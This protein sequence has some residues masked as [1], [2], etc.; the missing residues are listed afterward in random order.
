M[1]AF[2]NIVFTSLDS[3][4]LVDA[5]SYAW[6]FGDGVTTN[7]SSTATHA[8]APGTWTAKLTLTKNGFPVSTTLAL[9]VPAPPE[10]PKWVVP[11]MAYVL[12]QVAGTTWQSDVT[13]MNPSALS[14][15]YSVAFLDARNPVTDYSQLTWTPITVDPL[16]VI[17]SGNL[18][19]GPPFNQPLGAY[20]ALMV[21]GDVAPLPP[22]ITARTFNNGDPTKGT[23]G[24]SVPQSS[25]SG[26]VSTQAAAAA[27]VLIGL[28][29]NATAYT[30]IGL[31][32]LHNDWATVELDFYDGATAADLGTLTVQINPYQSYQINKALQDPR[33]VPAA[34]YSGS[35]DLYSVLVKVTEGTGVY[36]YAT[37]IDA[38][39]DRPDRRDADRV[40]VELVPDPRHR[41]ADRRERRALAEPGHDREPLDRVPQGPHGLL[42]RGVHRGRLL[43]PEQHRRR[44]QLR[45]RT[46]AV[47]GRLRQ[48][49]ARCTRASSPSATRR[50]TRTRSST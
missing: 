2:K 47:L 39:D 38:R 44:R 17:D 37:V 25:V 30:N 9:T 26:G 41:P 40:A 3:P 22:V 24:L 42:L 43:E 29:Q 8:Y 21:R 31:V 1:T 14:A 6:D 18:L 11:G 10:P 50:A 35:S 27:S 15:K 46:D 19:A 36:P 32:N 20:G 4:S 5:G 49:L 16:G 12:G 34:G 7:G 48:H 45:P 33:F 23:F 13:I 28:R